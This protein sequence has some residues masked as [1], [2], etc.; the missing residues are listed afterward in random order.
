MASQPTLPES[1]PGALKS[2]CAVVKGNAA[3]IRNM[4]AVINGDGPVFA[5]A[6]ELLYGAA[7]GRATCRV[8]DPGRPVDELEVDHSNVTAAALVSPQSWL[9]RAVRLE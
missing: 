4:R 1:R 6:L 5:N 8:Q 2:R 9:N 3:V 7:L